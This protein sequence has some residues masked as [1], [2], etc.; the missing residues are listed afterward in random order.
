MKTKNRICSF[1]GN[2][3]AQK[4]KYCSSCAPNGLSEFRIKKFEINQV[5]YDFLH[6]KQNG[7]CNICSQDFEKISARKIAVHRNDITQKVCGLLCWSCKNKLDVLE[8]K[9]F[10]A[11]AK[12]HIETSKNVSDLFPTVKDNSKDSDRFVPLSNT[13]YFGDC[14][15][16]I[17]KFPDEFFDLVYVD[18]PFG[19]NMVQRLRSV[20]SVVGGNSHGF[21]GK[22][23][24]NTL[25]TDMSYVDIHNDYVQ[26]FLFPLML[27]AKRILKRTGTFY[28]HLD[29]RYVH[30]AKIMMD[31]IFGKENFLNHIIWSYNYGGRGKDRFPQKH[32]DI[33]SYSKEEGSHVFNWDQI[34]KIPYKAPSLQK[35]PVRAAAGQVP[36]DVWEMTIVPTNSKARTGYP[37][38]KPRAI[39]ERI[40][41]ASSNP[42]DLVL[43]F[44]CG[45]GTTL[46][47]AHL[48]NR[49][50]IGI[51]NNPT[52]FA[53]MKERFAKQGISVS[54]AYPLETV[55]PKEDEHTSKPETDTTPPESN[56]D[57]AS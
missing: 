2:E 15:D 51:D 25:E 50:W 16:K 31:S 17:K 6:S 29:R 45:S 27:E 4:K 44:C 20:K 19:T 28:L 34:D 36:T 37:T 5:Q 30:Y 52:A 57:L 46:E 18:P 10:S 26:D 55:L 8:D 41:R 56:E 49:K 13:V 12:L 11:K 22:K 21:G 54:F 9:S 32:D 35:D 3:N 48:L 42:G 40:I 24:H 38:Q 33:L 47:A 7:K 1:C 53:V 14:L 23:Y 39:A 43:D